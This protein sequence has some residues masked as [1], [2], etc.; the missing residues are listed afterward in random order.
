MFRSIGGTGNVRWYKICVYAAE[1]L[2]D[3]FRFN[4]ELRTLSFE[5]NRQRGNKL[6]LES[7]YLVITFFNQNVIKIMT[8]PCGKRWKIDV[9]F[10]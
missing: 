6:N 2:P 3:S 4:K 9:K 8:L 10:I 5:E 1:Y 7:V